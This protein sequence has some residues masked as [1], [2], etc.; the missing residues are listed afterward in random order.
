MIDSVIGLLPKVTMPLPEPMVT[1]EYWHPSVWNSTENMPNILTK[2][3]FDIV[4]IFLWICWGTMRLDIT[5]TFRIPT[6]L[7]FI[8]FNSSGRFLETMK[9]HKKKIVA[10]HK[11]VPCISK[12]ILKKNMSLNGRYLYKFPA[13]YRPFGSCAHKVALAVLRGGQEPLPLK[14]AAV[15]GSV[16]PAFLLQSWWARDCQMSGLHEIETTSMEYDSRNYI[17]YNMSVWGFSTEMLAKVFMLKTKTN[18]QNCV[19]RADAMAS[20]FSGT[21]TCLDSVIHRL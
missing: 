6:P 2:L 7:C 9:F 3:P 16:T 8:L 20:S 1:F 17:K 21:R 11:N 15:H 19:K 4:L 12:V 10:Y 5:C 13:S 18:H 14:V